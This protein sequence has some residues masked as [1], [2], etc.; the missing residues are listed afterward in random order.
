LGASTLAFQLTRAT[1][2]FP[3]PVNEGDRRGWWRT[4]FLAAARF[5]DLSSSESLRLECEIRRLGLGQ[6]AVPLLAD[7]NNPALG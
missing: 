2:A 6:R 3:T 5:A 1:A 4:L 7:T